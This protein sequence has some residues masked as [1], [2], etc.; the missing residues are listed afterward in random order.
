[1]IYTDPSIMNLLQ[2]QRRLFMEAEDV[3]RGGG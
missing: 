3:V 1:M 2:H